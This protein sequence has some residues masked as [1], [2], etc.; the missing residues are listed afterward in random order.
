MPL[1]LKRERG[2]KDLIYFPLILLGQH[3]LLARASRR[4]GVCRRS[5]ARASRRRGLRRRCLARV[6]RR[7]GVRRR[8]LARAYRRRGLRRRVR[9]VFPEV[10][11]CEQVPVPSELRFPER[12]ELREFLEHISAFRV[13][14]IRA[15][16]PVFIEQRVYFFK[17]V[18][19]LCA[20][21]GG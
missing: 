21:T 10:E 19:F 16:V 12:E 5:L 8:V 2:G 14:E 13:T 11:C 17:A 9:A 6:R 3:A 18:F 7:R 20:E 15:A 4:R 1:L